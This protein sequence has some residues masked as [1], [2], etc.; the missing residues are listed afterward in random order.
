MFLH[1]R[2]EGHALG[3][4]GGKVESRGPKTSHPI[5]KSITI[6][7]G[8]SMGPRRST[9]PCDGRHCQW[10]SRWQASYRESYREKLKRCF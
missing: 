2:E 1:L 9:P 8:E 10:Q 5:C 7:I 6:G 3:R 4:D